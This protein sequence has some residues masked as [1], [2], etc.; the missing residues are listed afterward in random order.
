MTTPITFDP[1]P[2]PDM[3]ALANIPP[4]ARSQATTLDTN[5][6]RINAYLT[7]QPARGTVIGFTNLTAGIA[8][9]TPGMLPFTQGQWP[10]L[11][12]TVPPCEAIYVSINARIFLPGYA[13]LMVR[14]EPSGP[15]WR[16][17]LGSDV[18][19]QCGAAPGNGRWMAANMTYIIQAAWGLNIGQSMTLT[20][21]RH[22]TNGGNQIHLGLIT[23]AAV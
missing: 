6:D 10:K 22:S 18:N 11:T 5:F 19:L 21:A 17:A 16:G 15:G 8:G 9:D 14:A 20:P 23:V 1:V 7:A 12:F 2:A 13:W 4:W 3:E